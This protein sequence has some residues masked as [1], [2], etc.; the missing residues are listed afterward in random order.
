MTAACTGP[1][2]CSAGHLDGDELSCGLCGFVYGPD[3]QCV[4]VPTQSRVPVGAAVRA[5]PVREEQGLVWVWL[6]S[7]GAP[8]STGYRTCRGS[9]RTGGPPSAVSSW[10]TPGS[11][12]CTRA[13][14]TSPRFPCSSPRCRPRCSR[15]LR[16]RWTSRSPRPRC[17]CRAGTRR[18]RFRTGRRGRSAGPA[19]RS[20]STSRKGTSC[21][22]RPGLTT[23]MSC[24]T[25]QRSADP[26]TP[27]SPDAVH[28]ARHAGRRS[29][30]QAAVA[31]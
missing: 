24:S 29:R 30:Q 10:S 11:C 25:S 26:E 23:G 5:Y 15:Y 4:R 6:A 3:G 9:S 14:P 18:D 13:S 20:S 27:E 2:R 21:P 12:C 22:R 16:R 7:R 8:G 28:A 31:G 17:P 19:T 1:I